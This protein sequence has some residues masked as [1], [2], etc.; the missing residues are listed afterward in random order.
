VPLPARDHRIS[1]EEAAALTRRH[2]QARTTEE[3]AG[4]FHKDQLVELL[5]QPGCVGL[6]IYHGRKA[7]GA[8]AFVLV[9][10]DDATNDMVDGVMLEQHV[11]CPPFCSAAS[12]LNT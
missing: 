10:V 7:D 2:R 3:K 8:P 12:L 6:R 4:A 9:G 5:N 11:P 1:L